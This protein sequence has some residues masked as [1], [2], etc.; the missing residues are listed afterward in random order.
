MHVQVD[1][2]G[3]GLD[4]RSGRGVVVLVHEAS[5]RA[6]PLWVHDKDGAAV[7]RALDGRTTG[8]PDAQELAWE[9]IATL[10]AS[11]DHVEIVGV[12]G[13]V[14][15]ARVGLRFGDEQ[16]WLEARPSDACVLALRAGAP[17]LIE[18]ELL[19]QV[20]ARVRAAEA[21]AQPSRASLD[22]SPVLTVGERWNQLLQHLPLGP[23]GPISEA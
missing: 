15:Q 8:R 23:E 4:P 11:V 19:E 12:V 21:R 9:V 6:F 18:D 22:E 1:V 10:G 17:I 20:A 7:A 2:V 16:S 14:V 13:G 5:G 3:F